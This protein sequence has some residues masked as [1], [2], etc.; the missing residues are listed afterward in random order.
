MLRTS[1]ERKSSGATAR[2]EDYGPVKAQRLRERAQAEAERTAALRELKA[3]AGP[4]DGKVLSDQART[5]LLELH[6]RALSQAG[7]PVRHP[8]RAVATLPGGEQVVLTVAA[9]P[10]R[11]TT[12]RSPAGTLALH[13]LALSLS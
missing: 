10:G 11:T 1:G 13:E 4:L 12:L 3:L 6:A 2:R 9:A 7:G 5:A 8:A